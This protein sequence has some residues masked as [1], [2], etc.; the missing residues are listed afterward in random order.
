MPNA[1]S[2]G[3]HTVIRLPRAAVWACA[4]FLAIAFFFV[5]FSKLDGPSALRWTER[6]ARWGYPAN[7]QYVV[8]AFEILGG[9]GVL[10]PAW[11]RAAAAILVA[12]M[13]GALC[14]HVIQ[15]EF[16]RLIPPLV[17]GGLAFLLYS[18][19]V[20]RRTRTDVISRVGR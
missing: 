15:A 1:V 12:L 4:I 6:F 8:G 5:G 14:T 13:I 18:S 16:T 11:R 9:I 20:P 2:T 7:A 17:L 19:P 3:G 10:I